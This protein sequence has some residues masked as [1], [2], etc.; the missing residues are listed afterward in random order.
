MHFNPEKNQNRHFIKS[1][2]EQ[3]FNI[4]EKNYAHSLILTEDNPPRHWPVDSINSLKWE[5]LSE[6]HNLEHEVI[7]LGTGFNLIWPPE[8][9]LQHCHQRSLPIEVMTTKM[10]CQ[11]YNLLASDHRQVLAAL[12]FSNT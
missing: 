6:I 9:F 5:D 11:T 10:A 8:K 2:D 1:F 7:L 12:I 4:N 3:G